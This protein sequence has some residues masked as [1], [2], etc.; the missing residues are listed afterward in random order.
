MGR[1]GRDWNKERQRRKEE[2]KSRR[3]SL[4]YMTK[5]AEIDCR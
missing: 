4:L 5:S 1:H 3:K 2:M